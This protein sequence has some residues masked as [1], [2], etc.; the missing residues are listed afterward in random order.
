M[1]PPTYDVKNFEEGNST[2]TWFFHFLGSMELHEQKYVDK[3]KSILRFFIMAPLKGMVASV[4][5]H[6][7]FFLHLRKIRKKEI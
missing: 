3:K 2:L 5:I 1:N 7:R 4:G 6:T